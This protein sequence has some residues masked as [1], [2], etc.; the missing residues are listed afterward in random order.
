M[1]KEN[2]VRGLHDQVFCHWLILQR[3]GFDLPRG[4]LILGPLQNEAILQLID[5]TGCLIGLQQQ[6]NRL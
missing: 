5:F 3:K 6:T 2:G 4:S 1:K